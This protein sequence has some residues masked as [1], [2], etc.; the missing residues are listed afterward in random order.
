MSD[1]SNFASKL[2]NLESRMNRSND[3]AW[4][5]ASELQRDLQSNLPQLGDMYDKGAGN[6]TGYVS[7]KA[8]KQTAI[9]TWT[10]K[11]IWYIEFGTGTLAVGRYGDSAQ[12]A[13]AGYAPRAS[14]HSLGVY[15]TLPMDEYSTSD[16][17]PVVTKGWSP[18]APFYT[19][20]LHYRSGKFDPVIKK[21]V[22]KK[23]ESLL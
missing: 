15:W 22:K 23:L 19:T 18:Y 4:E 10:G 21:A 3:V 2:R 1:L 11:Q 6:E 14:G 7:A 13:E 8:A 17:K 12:M 9:L 5:L 20:Q 16:G